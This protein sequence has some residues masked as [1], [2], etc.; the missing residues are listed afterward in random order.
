MSGGTDDRA[1]T[2]KIEREPD[3]VPPDARLSARFSGQ[4]R[5]GTRPELLLRREL[6]GRGLR[7]RIQYPVPGLPR[8]TVDIA[9][10]RARLAVL[11]D[12]CFWH[13][14]PEHHVIPKA[15]REWWKWKF[16]TNQARDADTDARL[17]A[18]EWAVI[19]VWE[20]ESP[21]MGANRIQKWM[22]DPPTTRRQRPQDPVEC[23]KL[24]HAAQTEIEPQ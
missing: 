24:E 2:R 10:T 7:Y 21:D 8:R 13:S 19:R 17:L 3:R 16:A 12:G 9:F 4:A 5:K 1:P 18:L 14:C 11:V 15:N 23:W 6:H 22:S 20:H